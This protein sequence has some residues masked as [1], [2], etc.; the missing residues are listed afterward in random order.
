MTNRHGIGLREITTLLYSNTLYSNLNSQHTDFTSPNDLTL[1]TA[2]YY[3]H[4]STVLFECYISTPHQRAH[5]VIC[6]AVAT[7]T[8]ALG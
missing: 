3:D 2:P 1:S 5:I 6:L 4:I 7:P 8:R